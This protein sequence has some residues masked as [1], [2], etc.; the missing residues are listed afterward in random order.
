MPW[1]YL[2]LISPG[3]LAIIRYPV[4]RPNAT[5][6]GGPPWRAIV[7]ACTPI[8]Q[9]HGY[10][11]KDLWGLDWLACEG[12]T[13][14]VNYAEDNATTL[15]KLAAAYAGDPERFAAFTLYEWRG[16]EFVLVRD[17]TKGAPR[18]A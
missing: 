14:P 7:K 3:P 9:A 13:D 18:H 4:Q 2:A 15:P 17:A 5:R 10:R 11:A 6:D 8:M 16:T 1:K 12:W